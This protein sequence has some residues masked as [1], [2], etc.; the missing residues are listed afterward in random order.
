MGSIVQMPEPK[1]YAEC[2][3][4]TYSGN[5]YPIWMKTVSYYFSLQLRLLE[6]D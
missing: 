4:A 6:R 2:S 1:S 5:K 3:A